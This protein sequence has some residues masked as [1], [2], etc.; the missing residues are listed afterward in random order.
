[1]HNTPVMYVPTTKK[2]RTN[3]CLGYLELKIDKTNRIANKT[4]L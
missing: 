4:V 3:G 2:G 1:M